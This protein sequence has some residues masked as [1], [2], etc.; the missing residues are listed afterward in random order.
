MTESPMIDAAWAS[1]RA[2]QW[3]LWPGLPS[4]QPAAAVLN[5]LGSAAVPL[6]AS[7][8]L[9]RRPVDRHD[10]GPLHLWADRGSVVLVEWIDPPCATAVP[11]L[12]ATLGLPDR[13]AGGRYLRA[14]ATTTEYVYAGRGL[15]LTV[16]ASYEQPPGFAPYLATVQLF[17]PCSLR[18]FILEL[19]GNDTSGPRM[20]GP[21]PA[22]RR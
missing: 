8:R 6:G 16:A 19:G 18:D 2:G 12:L 3:A 21:G 11:E 4:G 20:V 13:E 10:A 22:V 9:G 14:G 17:T 7:S 15:A 5:A 1:A